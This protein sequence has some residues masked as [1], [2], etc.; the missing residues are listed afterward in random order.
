M[1]KAIGTGISFETFRRSRSQN[2]CMRFLAGLLA[3]AC[4]ACNGRAPET[5]QVSTLP[6]VMKEEISKP[7]EIDNC[8]HLHKVVDLYDLLKQMHDNLDSTCLFDID[9]KQLE[10]I[11]GLEIQGVTDSRVIRDAAGIP[12]KD[13]FFLK[14]LGGPL[15]QF[16]VAFGEGSINRIF[17]VRLTSN[18]Q[19]QGGV[20][21]PSGRLPQFLDNWEETAISGG[22]SHE[23]GIPMDAIRHRIEPNSD[24]K[25]RT[26][27]T[28][29][30]DD[31]RVPLRMIYFVNAKPSDTVSITSE[32]KRP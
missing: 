20:M 30:Y 18:Y 24:L 26:K 12:I 28:W 23:P 29:K 17:T 1:T 8:R 21:F 2:T 16:Y 6:A 22:V 32:T 14:P 13:N 27:Y 10:R 25:Y 31:G 9:P 19:R 3:L 7:R 4:A 5:M 15:D 11:W